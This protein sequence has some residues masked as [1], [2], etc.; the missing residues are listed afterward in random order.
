MSEVKALGRQGRIPE[1]KM[2]AKNLVQV[3]NA[4]AK[5]FQAGVQVAAI[6]N[7][8]RMAQTDA[9]MLGVMSAASGVMKNAN[10][11]ANPEKHMQMVQDFDMQSEKYK[12]NQEMTDEVLDSVLGGEDVDAETDDVLNSVLDEIGLE[13]SSKAGATP[14]LRPHAVQM[15]QPQQVPSV[16][17]AELMNRLARLG[18]PS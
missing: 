12:L 4:K 11:I 5:T 15:P 2:L 17:D 13:V 7:Q 18:G 14:A 16:D 8:A 3:R 6:G 9:T 10:E 1:A